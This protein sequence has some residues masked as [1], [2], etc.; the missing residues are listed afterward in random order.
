MWFCANKLSLNAK[1]TTYIL[2]SPKYKWC[3]FANKYILMNR[4]P[5]HRIDNDYVESFIKFFGISIDEHLSWQNHLSQVKSKLAELGFLSNNLKHILS[6][7]LLR[8]I[9]I[10]LFHPQL[11]YGLLVWGNAKQTILRK[12]KILQKRSILNIQNPVF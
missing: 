12:R 2:I 7:A 8:N 6:H 10:A 1:K 3:N 4:N 11:V 5:L 9:Y